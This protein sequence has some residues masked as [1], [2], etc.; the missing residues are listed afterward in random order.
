MQDISNNWSLRKVQIIIHTYETKKYLIYITNEAAPWLLILSC[1]LKTLSVEGVFISELIS[2]RQVSMALVPDNIWDDATLLPGSSS[3]AHRKKKSWEH[4]RRLQ[5]VCCRWLC[6]K[7]TKVL[8]Q[9]DPCETAWHWNGKSKYTINI[10]LCL[11]WYN[12]AN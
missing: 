11:Y 5:E 2:C 12:R 10:F 8:S 1:S 9:C 3:W 4:W 6:K 7:S